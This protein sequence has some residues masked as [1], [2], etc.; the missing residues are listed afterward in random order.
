M[1]AGLLSSTRFR[2]PTPQ[3]TK[4]TL[5]EGD[6]SVARSETMIQVESAFSER[7][8]DPVPIVSDATSADFSFTPEEGCEVLLDPVSMPRGSRAKTEDSALP[9]M[10]A[11]AHARTKGMCWQVSRTS[12]FLVLTR[13]TDKHSAYD[14]CVGRI[15][16]FCAKTKTG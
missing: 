15:S 5:H 2:D 3:A 13:R 16:D 1:L 8:C 9:P 7:L 12:N 14:R 10:S 11:L 6:I 4:F